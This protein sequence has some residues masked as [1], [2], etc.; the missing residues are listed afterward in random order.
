MTGIE[1]VRGHVRRFHRSVH[2]PPAQL[3]ENRA[4]LGLYPR[5]GHTL[6]SAGQDLDDSLRRAQDFVFALHLIDD[7]LERTAEE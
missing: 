5:E 6:I 3:V 2:E 1:W 4:R 7:A